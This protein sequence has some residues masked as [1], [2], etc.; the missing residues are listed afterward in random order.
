MTTLGEFRQD[1]YAL[2]GKASDIARTLALSALAIVWLFKVDGPKPG[3]L[4]FAEPLL[5]T[6]Y[7]A[8]AALA[9]DLVQYCWATFI[10]GFWSRLKEL[11]GVDPE[12]ELLAP[13]SFNWPTILLFWA[14]QLTM[15]YAYF[16]LL[17]YVSGR[18]QI[19]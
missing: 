9:L 5:R 15:A 16:V 17:T 10:W 8:I 13:P 1:Y 11:S 18:I 12:Q 4:Q 3:E 7:A 2:S 6:A 14:K 19:A